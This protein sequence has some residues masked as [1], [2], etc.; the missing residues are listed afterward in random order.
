MA[1]RLLLRFG[2]AVDRATLRVMSRAFQ[3]PRRRDA[4]VR[5]PA[6]LLEIGQAFYSSPETRARYFAP[7]GLPSICETARERL[8]AG[9]ILELRWDSAFEPLYPKIADEYRGYVE[10]AIAHARHLRHDRPARTIVFIHGWGG[11]NFWLE[12]RAFAARWFYRL[13]YDVLLFQLPFHGL[14]TPR[15][16]RFSG[17]LFPTANVFRT[18]EAFAQTLCDLRGLVGWLQ[19][20]GV[21]E[22]GLMG[23]SLGGYATALCAS[24]EPG[25]AFA[26]PMIPAVSFAELLWEHGKGSSERRAAE[27]AGV[28][29]AAL[30]RVFAVHAPLEHTPLVPHARRFIIAGVGDRIT[31]PEQA[32]LLWEHWQRPQI[33]WFDGAH[34]LQFGRG[35]AYRA[36]HRFLA[37]IGPGTGDGAAQPTAQASRRNA[38]SSIE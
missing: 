25:C 33:H 8:P 1:S 31:P 12:E 15:Q 11:G 38:S 14:R 18:N 17:A 5:D 35:D 16:A 13:G 34:L 20:R 26:I 23:M 36:V 10:N 9:A 22:V 28:T 24:C 37:G 21:P 6:A 2:S 7:P 30:E 19:G 27:R 29:K 4:P 32:R 3:P